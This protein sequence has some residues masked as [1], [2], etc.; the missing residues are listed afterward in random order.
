[1]KKKTKSKAAKK[2][3]ARKPSKAKAKVKVKA[4]SKPK[5]RAKKSSPKRSKAKVAAAPPK[6]GVIA[7][8]NSVLLGFVEDY[9]A[10]IGVIALTLQAPVAVGQKIQVLGHT[11]N[12]QQTVDSM[13]ID[14]VSVTQ[15]GAKDSVGI[16]VINR[17]RGGDHVYLLR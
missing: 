9:F 12:V 1:M 2:T 6:P 3:K 10:K 16:K 17:A 8:T 7:P 11:T 5:A 14:H 4:K 15:A 13:Q